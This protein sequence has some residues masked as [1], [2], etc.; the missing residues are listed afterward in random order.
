[1]ILP[2]IIYG[3]PVLRLKCEA[4]PVDYTNIQELISNL[5]ETMYASKGVGIAG[6]QVGLPL[7]IFVVDTSPFADDQDGHSN[8]EQ[9][10][11]LKFKKVFINPTITLQ[12]G[13]AWK[14]NEGCLSIPGIREDIIRKSK[15]CISYQDEK[16]EIH[17]QTF[18]GIIARVIQH[19]YDHIEGK[20]FIDHLSP[21]KL[22]ALKNKL[23][24]IS[25]GKFKAQYNTEVFNKI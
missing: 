5:F 3:H 14:F 11:L 17:Q 18:T 22:K 21:F 19:E 25:K 23:S 13:T 6:P 8:E 1:M 20:L 2:I 4:I 15:I 12:E 7:R 24:N 16:F 9:Q 10:E